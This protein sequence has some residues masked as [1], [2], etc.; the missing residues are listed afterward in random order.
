M[1]L[2]QDEHQEKIGSGSGIETVQKRVRWP[3][4]ITIFSIHRCVRTITMSI[5]DADEHAFF[6]QGQQLGLERVRV[7]GLRLVRVNCMWGV[8]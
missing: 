5:D 2:D 6:F 4:T 3:D 1:N 8:G 7:L